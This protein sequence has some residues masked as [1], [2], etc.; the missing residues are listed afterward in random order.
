[1]SKVEHLIAIG[2]KGRKSVSMSAGTGQSIVC[3]NCGSLKRIKGIY[4]ILHAARKTSG[5]PASEYPA[6]KKVCTGGN[7]I[8]SHTRYAE[9]GTGARCRVLQSPVWLV[10]TQGIEWGSF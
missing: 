9:V 10:F 1:M 8:T 2:N 5:P 3:W 7:E 4:Q 6:V